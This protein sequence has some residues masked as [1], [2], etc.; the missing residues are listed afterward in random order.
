MVFASNRGF[1][2]HDSRG[3]EP[4]GIDELRK[5]RDFL[6][7]RSRENSLK[8]Q[9]HVIWWE[10]AILI[11]PL[12]IFNLLCRYCISMAERR[13]FT[14]AEVH[15]FMNAGFGK[16][17]HRTISDELGGFIEQPQFQ[18]LLYSQSQMFYVS[19]CLKVWKRN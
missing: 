6:T 14:A 13:P 8:K 12:L 3:Q 7:T 18:L 2:F 11:L 19:N 1:I 4:G 5:V 16:G 9:V 17:K 10:R 15:F